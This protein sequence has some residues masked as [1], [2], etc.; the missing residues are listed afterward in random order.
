MKMKYEQVIR[1]SRDFVWATYENPHNLPRWQPTL[2]SFTH[3]SGQPGQLGAVSE[4]VYD[5]NGRNVVLTE[6]LTEKRQP[7]FVAVTSESKWGKALIVN[8]FEAI[9]ENTTRFVSYSNMSFRG[10]KKIMSLFIANSIRA[11]GE[12]DLNRFKLLVETE[13]AGTQS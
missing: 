1:A 11:R 2:K 7:H 10:I 12:A 5:D 6:T 8:H 4:L 3:K 13:A 9:D